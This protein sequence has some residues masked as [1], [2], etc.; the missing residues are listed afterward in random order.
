MKANF[1]ITFFS[2]WHCGTGTSGG[3]ETDA[4]IVTDANGFPFVP[5]KTIKG[6]LREAAEWYCSF[7]PSSKEMLV[8]IFGE[9]NVDK[10]NENA[11]AVN[12]GKAFFSDC[13]L[14]PEV[15]QKAL[16]KHQALFTQRVYSTA[17][18]KEGVA[19]KHSLRSMEVAIP[20][21][22]Y[23]VITNLSEEERAFL[24]TCMGLVKEL[25]AGKTRGLGKCQLTFI[26]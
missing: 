20:I 10:K 7:H 9:E 15:V 8:S 23:G 1:K 14:H 13:Y 11:P 2:F 21:S 26:A 16:S 17:I 5:G 3:T 12:G 6:H 24:A 22:V 4:L 25:G 18:E 19:K